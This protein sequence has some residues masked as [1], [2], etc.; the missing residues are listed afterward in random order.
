MPSFQKIRLPPST[1]RTI[2]RT[3]LMILACAHELHDQLKDFWNT[4]REK[5]GVFVGHTGA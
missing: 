5:A 3:Q 1:L 2:D 4:H